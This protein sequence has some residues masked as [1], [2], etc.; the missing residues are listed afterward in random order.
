MTVLLFSYF[1]GYEIQ[2]Y[3]TIDRTVCIFPLENILLES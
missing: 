2:G 3:L 1:N